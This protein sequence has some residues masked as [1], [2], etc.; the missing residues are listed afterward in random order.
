MRVAGPPSV[1]ASAG[2]ASRGGTDGPRDERHRSRAG[3]LAALSPPGMPQMASTAVPPLV[4]TSRQQRAL[5]R[6]QRESHFAPIALYPDDLL[7][8]A[9]YPLKVMQA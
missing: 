7:M 4:A 2:G 1:P 5:T 9:A 6:A 3:V 8:A